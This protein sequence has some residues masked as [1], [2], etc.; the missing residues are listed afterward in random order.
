MKS[1]EG[2]LAFGSSSALLPGHQVIPVTGKLMGG[3][4]SSW[5]EIHSHRL[6]RRCNEQYMSNSNAM[7][8]LRLGYV[9]I[10]VQNPVFKLE[11]EPPSFLVSIFASWILHDL[12]VFQPSIFRPSSLTQ[13]RE[14]G[15]MGK[16]GEPRTASNSTTS[17]G[18]EPMYNRPHQSQ[19][20]QWTLPE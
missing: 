12:S 4:L 20:E 19:T 1:P 17:S 6:V 3:C 18:S 8:G 13:L 2:I 15:F 5:R 9:Q 10:T 14:K 16:P 11:H 7:Q